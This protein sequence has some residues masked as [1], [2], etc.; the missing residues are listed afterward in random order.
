MP[1]AYNSHTSTL[2]RPLQPGDFA[3]YAQAQTTGEVYTP[4]FIDAQ[5]YSAQPVVHID[6]VHREAADLAQPAS[7]YNSNMY[8][9]PSA[10]MPA[11]PEVVDHQVATE[12]AALVGGVENMLQQEAEPQ[13]NYLDRMTET[14]NDY[15]AP[16]PEYSNGAQ[17]LEAYNAACA[18]MAV[19][20]ATA[21]AAGIEHNYN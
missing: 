17:L 6:T 13:A 8:I 2:D 5:E 18:I 20:R 14:E 9:R 21:T 3:R 16:S 15:T 12:A 1:T 7:A 10:E 4:D 11:S 19:R